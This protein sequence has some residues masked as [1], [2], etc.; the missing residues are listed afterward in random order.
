M[1]PTTKRVP[2]PEPEM[3]DTRPLVQTR[4]TEMLGKLDDRV[5]MHASQQKAML[6]F[7]PAQVDE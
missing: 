3:P 4:V 7:E 2:L 5:A 6:A 1:P